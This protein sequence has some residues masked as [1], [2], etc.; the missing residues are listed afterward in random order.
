MRDLWKFLVRVAPSQTAIQRFYNALSRLKQAWFDGPEGASPDGE[1]WKDTVR[2][3]LA[4][5][6][7]LK[8]IS[9]ETLTEAI[10]HGLLDRALKWHLET[11]KE[12]L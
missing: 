4:E 6:L 7:G 5:H 1:L 2:A 8:G 11:L 9:L 3:L 10:P 12:G